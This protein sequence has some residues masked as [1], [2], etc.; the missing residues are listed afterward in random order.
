MQFT[1]ELLTKEISHPV[2]PF[3]L[4]IRS[5]KDEKPIK[6]EFNFHTCTL[7]Y[8][9]KEWDRI[10]NRSALNGA[11]RRDITDCVNQYICTEARV[12]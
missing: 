10:I 3:E 11:I 6:G 12:L 5:S 7:K 8:N 1:V 2:Y 4:H 9:L